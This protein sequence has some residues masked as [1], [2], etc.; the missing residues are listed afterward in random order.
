MI[1]TISKSTGKKIVMI[2]LNDAMAPRQKT[3]CENKGYKL[4]DC[5]TV[6][7]TY[8]TKEK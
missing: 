6:C 7:M 2:M 8:E 4:I 5:N 1:H 3:M